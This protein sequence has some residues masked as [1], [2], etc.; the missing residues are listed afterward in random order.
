MDT[1]GGR[2]HIFQIS[3]Y[4]CGLDLSPAAVFLYH[5]AFRIKKLTLKSEVVGDL[6]N[7]GIHEKVQLRSG[8]ADILIGGVFPGAVRQR[9]V[10]GIAFGRRKT[11][12]G[13]MRLMDVQ[14]GAVSKS[15][16]V[17][18]APER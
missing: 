9:Q 14:R 17:T 4:V 6:G 15:K 10:D 5:N 12:A 1:P 11:D 7:S 16:A 8:P 18:A 13:D 3:V 2:T